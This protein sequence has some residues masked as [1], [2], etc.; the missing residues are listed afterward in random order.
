[1]LKICA[2]IITKDPDSRLRERVLSFIDSV[3]HLIIVDNGSQNASVEIIDQVVGDTQTQVIRNESNL[4]VAEALNI[5][6]HSALDQGNEWVL[7]LDQ[8][9]VP[10]PN[11]IEHL[12]ASF[13]KQK[14][15]DYIAIVAPRIIDLEVER[16]ALFLRRRSNWFYQRLRCTEADLDKI[17]TVITS[18][19]L[20]RLKCFNELGGFREDLFIDYV[21]TDFC[22]RAIN[23]G[24][25]ILVSCNA[26]L[27]HQFGTRRMVKRGPMTLYPSFH[28]PERWYT[29][30]R[31]RIP[32]IRSFGLKNPHWF[33]YELVA[34]IYTFWRMILSE[35]RKLEKISAMIR[36]TL[37]GLR[38]RLGAP[39]WAD[40]SF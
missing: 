32:M 31:N 21:D 37:D 1:M 38:S 20:I 34:T 10:A 29:I 11:M 36:G 17:T 19:A 28:P 13:N 2:L 27:K 3:D 18:G 40:E 30:S 22:L 15:Q 12:S 4:G 5:G 23:K 6:A 14:Q 25:R 33:S 26:I 8:D 24:Y 16:E 7:T 9:S 39:Y 35:D